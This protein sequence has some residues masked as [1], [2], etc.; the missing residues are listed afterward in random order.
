MTSIEA[1]MS[2]NVAIVGGG[3]GGLAAALSLQQKGINV[4][5]YERDG[6][7]GD[8]RQGYGLTLTNNKKG[9]LAELGLLKKCVDQD[10][11]SNAH[12]IFA[13]NGD[14]LGYYGRAF[15][16]NPTTTNTAKSKID[17]DAVEGRGNLRIPRESLRK[18]L[19]DSLRPGTV[20]WGV[21]LVDYE[22]TS[23]SVKLKFQRQGACAASYDD[24][25]KSMTAS[26][27]EKLDANS[28]TL[29]QSNERFHHESYLEIDAD[30]LVGA[31]GMR[32]VVRQLRYMKD[33]NAKKRKNNP[34]DSNSEG[35]SL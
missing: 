19:L 6:E 23:T 21:K 28:A 31:D 18:M 3:I 1:S 27:E 17:K 16:H 32:S 34:G 8:R 35:I 7:F 13:P 33:F 29:A 15:K 5:V 11:P 26:V 22:E 25:A 9:P 2:L 4:T 20:A 24:I 10:C 30:V 12:W 14:I